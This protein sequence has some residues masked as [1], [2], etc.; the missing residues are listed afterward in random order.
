MKVAIIGAG[1]AGLTCAFEL[2][3]YGIFA[4]IYEQNSFIGE[5]ISHVSCLLEVTHRPIGNPIKYMEEK[6]NLKINPLNTVKKI[7][8][9]SPNKTA[10]VKGNLGYFIIRGREKD[11]FKAQVYSK[12]KGSKI[13]FNSPGDYESLSKEYDYVVVANGNSNITQELGCWQKWFRGYERGAT[14]LGDFD[15]NTLYM[16]INKD[17]CK[18]GYAYMCPYSNKKAF[19]T[20]IVSDVNKTE[21]DQYWRNFLYTESLKY[22][23]IEEFKLEHIGGHAYPHKVGNIYFAGNAAGALDPFLGFGQL[24]SVIMGVY[25][26]R[27]IALDMDYEQLIK[28]IVR[29]SFDMYRIRKAYNNLTNKDYDNLISF[30]GL[31]GVR[32]LI[33]NSR[34][35]IVKPASLFLSL[36]KDKEK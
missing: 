33:Y 24:N 12:L 23:I 19:V 34:F 35:N 30:M 25:A 18:N 22:T 2:E 15:P 3:K 4:D 5:Q 7:V 29:R 14:I 9:K 27:S 13:L 10:V 8:H 31:P 6:F 21:V 11:D 20:L 1:V 16:W 28:D 32:N 17:Y 36:K 26:A